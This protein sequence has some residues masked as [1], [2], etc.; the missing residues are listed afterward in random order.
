MI[1]F[2]VGSGI[3]IAGEMPVLRISSAKFSPAKT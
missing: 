2:L 3:S 1:S